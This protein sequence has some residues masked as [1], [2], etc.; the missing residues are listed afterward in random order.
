MTQSSSEPDYVL[1]RNRMVDGQV[2]PLQ[3]SD[4]RIIKAMR[5]MPRERFV[6][7]G[8]AALAYADRPVALGSG[9]VLMEPRIIAR[10]LQ[11]AVPRAGE[12]ALVVAAGTGYAAAL[13]S[14]LGL[15]VIA[16]EQ[17]PQLAKEGRGVCAELAPA[18]RFEHGTLADGWPAGAPYELILIDGAVRALPPAMAGQ[19]AAGGRLAAVLCPQGRVGTAVLAEASNG[20]LRGRPQFDAATPLIPELLAGPAFEF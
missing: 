9:R 17:D 1:A 7:A 6:P 11:T 14:R 2:R 16:L 13:L 4:A 5:E 8:C 19:L 18:V 3:V 15:R 20:G 12:R 10:M